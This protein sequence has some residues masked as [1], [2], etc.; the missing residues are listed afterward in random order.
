MKLTFIDRDREIEIIRDHIRQG[1][2]LHLYGPEGVG[3]SA[4]IEH[5]YRTWDEIGT[6]RIPIYCKDSETLERILDTIARSLL[7]QGKKLLDI[8]YESRTEKLI[9][10][11]DDVSTVPRRNLRNMVFPHIKRGKF[12]ITLDHLEN[13]TSRT[14]SFLKALYG[15]TMIITVSRGDLVDSIAGAAESLNV[16][17]LPMGN[18]DKESAI[19]LMERLLF[20]TGISDSR[21]LFEDAYAATRGNPLQ[22]ERMFAEAMH[23]KQFRDGIPR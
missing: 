8:D 13:V 7:L 19:N 1:K 23:T 11:P 6:L 2:S 14:N 15:S 20:K 9:L 16:T 21:R 5:V 17:K 10:Q 12:C 22:I 4:L 3:K 18:L